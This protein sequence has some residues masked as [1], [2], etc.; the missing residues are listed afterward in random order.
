MYWEGSGKISKLIKKFSAWVCMPRTCHY[1]NNL[2]L[3]PEN[4][5]AV[6]EVSPQQQAIGHYRMKVVVVVNHYQSVYF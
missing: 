4:L 2:F 6:R 3:Q 5:Y 1:S